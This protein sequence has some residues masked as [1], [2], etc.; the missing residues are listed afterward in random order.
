MTIDHIALSTKYRKA[1]G[2]AEDRGK[3]EIANA[4]DLIADNHWD[5]HVS[6]KAIADAL[7]R[8]ELAGVKVEE[9]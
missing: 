2:R 9:I 7:A 6:Q 5:I 4:L 1:A 3:H 8:L